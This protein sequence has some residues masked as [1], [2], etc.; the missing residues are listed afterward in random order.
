MR[1][2][3]GVLAGYSSRR[4]A[5]LGDMLELGETE[6]EEHRALGREAAGI[7]DVLV[8][9]GPRSKETVK[10][11]MEAGL[12]P[13]AVHSFPDSPAAASVIP[14]LIRADDTILLKGSRGMR[15]EAIADALT[16]LEAVSS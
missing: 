16:S 15:M 12:S 13:D 10:A 1:A 11:A 2:A 3:L 7:A 5:I 6:A 8:T 4:V 14:S 9:V